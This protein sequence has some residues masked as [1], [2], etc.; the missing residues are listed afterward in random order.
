MTELL[1]TRHE[2][3]PQ[4]LELGLGLGPLN[5]VAFRLLG[6][7]FSGSSDSRPLRLLGL[8]LLGWLAFSA[9]PWVL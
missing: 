1:Q 3:Q 6:L 9:E 7:P 8:R 4:E 2:P 5:H